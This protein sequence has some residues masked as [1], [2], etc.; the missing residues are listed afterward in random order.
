VTLSVPDG[1]ESRGAVLALDDVT[2]RY[3][4]VLAVDH[5][6]FSIE[7]GSLVGLIG[8]NG[9]GKTTLVDAI[10]GCVPY[11]GNV[12]LGGTCL[13]GLPPHKRAVAGVCRTFQS[14]EL[15]EDLTVRE[16]LLIGWSGGSLRNLWAELLAGRE[17]NPGAEFD[18]LL[19][20]LELDEVLD[21]EGKR[22]TQGQRKIVGLARGLASRPKVLLLDEPAAGLDTGESVR[23]GRKLREIC[24]QGTA[25]MLIEHDMNLV[26]QICDSIQVIDIG[27]QIAQGSPADIRGNPMVVQ[28]YLG[29]IHADAMDQA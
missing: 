5:V 25:I 27:H 1:T 17:P 4:N 12:S 29:D 10:C 15:F 18:D 23:L 7:P 8:P 16:N 22:L 14:A 13:D 26:M 21:L 6:S 9:A 11:T 3:R 20:F 28:A 24:D 2:V 19:A